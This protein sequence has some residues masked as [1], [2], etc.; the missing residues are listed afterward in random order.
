MIPPLDG[1]TSNVGHLVTVCMH[2]WGHY[3]CNISPTGH[4]NLTKK[5]LRTK[6]DYMEFNND[7]FT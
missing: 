7:L 5:V 6:I 3:C 1:M 4:V 2:Q